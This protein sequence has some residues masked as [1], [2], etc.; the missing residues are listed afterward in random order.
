M[1]DGDAV[2]A[3]AAALNAELAALLRRARDNGVDVR[4]GWTCPADA[5]A[6]DWDVVVT[7]VETADRPG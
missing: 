2:P 5:D 4:G 3:S 1:T 6:P 7:E